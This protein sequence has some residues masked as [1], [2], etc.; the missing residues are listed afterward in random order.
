[1]ALERYED[2][3]HSPPAHGAPFT[4]TFIRQQDRSDSALPTAITLTRDR[5]TMKVADQ[6]SYR[7]YSPV[8]RKPRRLGAP[9]AWPA[10][11]SSL[12]NLEPK[13]LPQSLWPSITVT[14]PRLAQKDTGAQAVSNSL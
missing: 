4:R 13:H 8:P 9:V 10:A 5:D 3:K 14:L 7:M 2:L 1:Q 12:R 11:E 6:L